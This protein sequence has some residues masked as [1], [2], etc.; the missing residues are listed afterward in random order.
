[1][2]LFPNRLLFQGKWWEGRIL[3]KTISFGCFIDNLNSGCAVESSMSLLNMQTPRL[4]PRLDEL[5][6]L[7]VGYRDTCIL[8]SPAVNLRHS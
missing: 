2:L 7:G 8:K 1:M 6:K 3:F 5:E 4:Y